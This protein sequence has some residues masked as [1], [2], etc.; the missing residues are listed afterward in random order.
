MKIDLIARRRHTSDGRRFA[1]DSPNRPSSVESNRLAEVLS[2]IDRSFSVF[3]IERATI[4]RDSRNCDNK[5]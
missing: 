4:R 3:R 2:D 5:S 1:T